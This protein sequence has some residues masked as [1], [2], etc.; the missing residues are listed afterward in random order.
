VAKFELGDGEQVVGE[1]EVSLIDGREAVP[2]S[3][4]THGPRRP[5]SMPLPEA[6]LV[7]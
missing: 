7:R 1:F 2:S 3:A 6:K 5:A 4:C